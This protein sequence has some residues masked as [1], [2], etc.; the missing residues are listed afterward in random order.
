[1]WGEHGKMKE[2]QEIARNVDIPLPLKCQ[3][4]PLFIISSWNFVRTCIYQQT[5]FNTHVKF[6]FN[7][8]EEC[9]NDIG[10]QKCL[11]IFFIFSKHENPD[12]DFDSPL[13]CHLSE[14]TNR[15]HLNN[16]F[17]D[18]FC[19]H[20]PTSLS[21]NRKTW[22]HSAVVFGGHNTQRFF[23]PS[24]YVEL[25][26]E[27][28]RNLRRWFI[29]YFWGYCGKAWVYPHPVSRRQQTDI[30]I[31]QAFSWNSFRSQFPFF[32]FAR[33]KMCVLAENYRTVYN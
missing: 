5:L 7:W 28:V 3:I 6:F 4:R 21:R 19:V 2:F 11:C 14:K 1:M 18:G 33:T 10:K 13:T 8:T 24:I 22:S 27:R 25:M 15:F 31:C 16:C 17:R 23:L 20:K 12:I 26:K 9:L 29:H 32:L 30:S